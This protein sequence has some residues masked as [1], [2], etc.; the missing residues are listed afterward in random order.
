MKRKIFSQ[1]SLLIALFAIAFSLSAC[2]SQTSTPSATSTGTYSQTQTTGTT[3]NATVP[4]PQT[5][6]SLFKTLKYGIILS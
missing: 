2:S 5:R 1:I 4:G 3:Q 6:Q